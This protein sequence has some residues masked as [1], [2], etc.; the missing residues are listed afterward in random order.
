MNFKSQC[1]AC[2]RFTV[3]IYNVLYLILSKIRDSNLS[4]EII[5]CFQRYLQILFTFKHYVYLMSLTEIKT[6]LL[7]KI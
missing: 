1:E 6:L 5:E 3:L 7:S 2:D 4:H